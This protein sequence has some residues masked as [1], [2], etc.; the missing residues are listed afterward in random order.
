MKRAATEKQCLVDTLIK[1]DVVTKEGWIVKGL[2]GVYSMHIDVFL[3]VYLFN[4]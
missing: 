3:Y 4:M 2:V 1:M